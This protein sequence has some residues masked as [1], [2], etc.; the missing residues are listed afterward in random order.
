MKQE[1]TVT[2]GLGE[3]ARLLE[4][5][6]DSEKKLGNEMVTNMLMGAMLAAPDQRD[7]FLEEQRAE[8]RGLDAKIEVIKEANIL[9]KA[10]L[11][12]AKQEILAT[13]A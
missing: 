8:A 7:A 9:L 11:L 2:L 5:L 13:P 3:I 4:G 1:T 6:S 12:Q 10:K